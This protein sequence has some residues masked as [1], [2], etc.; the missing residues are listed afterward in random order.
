MKVISFDNGIMIVGDKDA[1]EYTAAPSFNSTPD[2]QEAY[3]SAVRNNGLAEEAAVVPNTPEPEQE[4]EQEFK[5]VVD[6]DAS[7]ESKDKAE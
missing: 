4:P 1:P 2:Q 6:S 5:P 7:D 3:A